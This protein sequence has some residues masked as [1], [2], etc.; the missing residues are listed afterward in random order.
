MLHEYSSFFFRFGTGSPEKQ[1]FLLVFK[2]FSIEICDEKEDLPVHYDDPIKCWFL[3][4]G[5]AE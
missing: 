3:D 4:Q 2:F 5:L 1:Y